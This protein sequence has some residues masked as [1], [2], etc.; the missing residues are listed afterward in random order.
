MNRQFRSKPRRWF[1]TALL[2]LAVAWMAKLLLEAWPEFVMSLGKLNSGW[3]LLTLGGNIFAAYLGF[4][5]F[6]ALL[7]IIHTGHEGRRFLGHLY[8][9]GQLMKHLP[10]RIWG[11]A[12]Q[13]SK[14]PVVSLA[15]WVAVSAA[16]MILSTVIALWIAAIVLGMTKFMVLGLVVFAVGVALFFVAWNMALLTSASSALRHLPWQGA[17]SLATAIEPFGRVTWPQK[18]HVLIWFLASWSIYLIAWAGFG[19]AW[20]R[21]SAF[22]GIVLCA[23][24]TLA[25]FIGYVTLISPSGM[26]VRELAFAFIA[27]R[28]PPDVIA[29]MAIIGRV[30]LLAT[31]VFLGMAFA[32]TGNSSRQAV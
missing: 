24:Y 1:V 7:L 17:K 18:A 21:L 12:Y 31:D 13:Y 6:R 20:P 14:S 23:M 19:M 5:A 9:T 15:E 30:M 11:V 16:Y 29:G 4:E 2:I 26:G 3:L 22:D 28:Y 25:W 32:R 10:G 8:F 27:H